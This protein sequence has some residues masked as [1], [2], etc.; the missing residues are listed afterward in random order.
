MKN[1]R[2]GAAQDL[3]R[4]IMFS[5]HPQL[6]QDCIE[7]GQTGLCTLL[8]MNDKNYPWYIL[9]PQVENISE[10]HHLSEAQR[11]Q[12]FDESMLLSHALEQAYQPDKLNIAALGNIVP[13]LH[14][15]HIV[16][17]KNDAAWPAPVWGKL[18]PVKYTKQESAAVI[19]R[20][21]AALPAGVI[22][23]AAPVGQLIAS[24]AR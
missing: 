5:L 4:A 9:V 19:T 13:Q 6:A 14:I 24:A 17:Y 20:L 21:L 15:H 22:S 10:I 1:S 23:L 8:L 3:D 18:P 16:R 7:L 11:Q 2:C 12:L